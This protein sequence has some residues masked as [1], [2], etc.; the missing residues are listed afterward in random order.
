MACSTTCDKQEKQDP[1][2]HISDDK[3][4]QV[5]TKVFKTAGGLD[6]YRNMKSISYQKQSILFLEDGSTESHITQRH[7]Y[8]LQPELTGDINW[9]A[10]GNTYRIHYS[11]QDSYKEE[12]GVR[13]PDSEESARKS[14]FSATYVLFIPFKLLDPGAELTYEGR[15]TLDDGKI[16]DVIR[17]EY[18]ATKHENHSTSEIWWYYFDAKDGSHLASLVFHP[19]TYAYIENVVITDDYDIRFNVHRKTFR[20]DASRNK[21]YLRGEFNYSNYV[22]NN[23]HK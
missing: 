14:F 15:D 22:I 4:L 20:T 10:D 5:L 21:E 9:V 11:A 13:I 17:A 19:P 1:M 2:A 16:A 23:I 18:D 7:S 3:V 6:N 8:S 12:N